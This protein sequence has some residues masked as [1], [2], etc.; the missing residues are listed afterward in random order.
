ME[1]QQ[2][3]FQHDSD[4]VRN[5]FL[6]SDLKWIKFE[7]ILFIVV[8]DLA[9]VITWERSHKGLNFP[10]CL[11][12]KKQKEMKVDCKRWRKIYKYTQN[13][14]TLTEKLLIKR[15]KQDSF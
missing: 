11:C 13:R 2:R 6:D 1:S 5:V 14:M 10:V 15:E 3:S 9:V 8:R 4:M 7:E 12:V